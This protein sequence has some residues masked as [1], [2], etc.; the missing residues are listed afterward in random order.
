MDDTRDEFIDND[1]PVDN[2]EFLDELEVENNVDAC[3]NLNP[4]PEW[5]MSNIWDDIHDPSPSLEIGLMSWRLGDESSKG[6][7]FKN[8]A[9]VQHALTM[10]SI[11]LN[12]KFKYKKLDPKRLVVTC[13]H[14]AC[15]WSV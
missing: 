12:K 8:K 15:P 14:D 13:V 1:G 7:I 5:F 6:M 11:G 9:A 10:F 2:P 4:N 3:P